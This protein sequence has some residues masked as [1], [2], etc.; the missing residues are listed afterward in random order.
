MEPTFQVT[1][2][3][4][5]EPG[6]HFTLWK[7]LLGRKVVGPGIAD[8]CKGLNMLGMVKDEENCQTLGEPQ[9]HVR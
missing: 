5:T 1:E 7:M 8:T 3:P 2:M 4:A 9:K 6:D